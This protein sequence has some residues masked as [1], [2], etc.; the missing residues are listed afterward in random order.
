MFRSKRSTLVKRLWKSR[1]LQNETSSEN[2]RTSTTNPDGDTEA[3]CVA[4]SMLKRLKEKQLEMLVE[5]IESKGGETKGCVLLPNADL[6]LGKRSVQP[7][8]LCC[9]LWRW[10]DITPNTELKRLPPC[11]SADDPAY[12]CCN[13]YHWSIQQKSGNY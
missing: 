13:P 2:E 9:Q 12:V 3:K 8:I 11:E 6:R 7:H 1:V 4:Q 10:P 5:S